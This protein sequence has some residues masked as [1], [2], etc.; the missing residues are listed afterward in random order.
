MALWNFKGTKDTVDEVS[1][2]KAKLMTHAKRE[3]EIYRRE[4]TLKIKEGAHEGIANQINRETKNL[5][6][7]YEN[8][9]Q[10]NSEIAAL[11]KEA[12]MRKM[13][14]RDKGSLQAVYFDS[15]EKYQADLLKAKNDQIKSLQSQV[16]DLT[17]A[18]KAVGARSE[19][20]N[21]K[22]DDK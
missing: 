10:A 15:I 16:S 8:K 6:D 9:E 7:Y 21:V 12:E 3:V 4:Q 1:E 14:M 11:K 2:Y 13:H 19:T 17:N 22:V 5:R 18:L 20:L